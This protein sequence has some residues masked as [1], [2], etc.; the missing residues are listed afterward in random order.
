MKPALSIFRRLMPPGRPRADW[1]SATD[2]ELVLAARVQDAAGKGAFVEIVRRHQGAVAAVAF[3][4]A[5]R[6]AW[7]DDITQ[8]TF[9]RVWQRLGTLREPGKFKAWLMRIAH[10]CAV[11]AVRKSRL[12]VPMEEAALDLLATE[13]DAPDAAAIVREEEAVV[14]TALEQ[15]PEDLRLPLVLYYQKGQSSVEVAAALDLS[16]AA[17][18]QRLSR[19]RDALRDLV[20]ARVEGVLERVRPSP[21][22]LAGVA[23]AIGWLASPTVVAGSAFTAAAATSSA[24][25]VATTMST[26][27]TS[28]AIAA[29]LAAAA[30]PFGYG[31]RMGM[32][33]SPAVAEDPPPA[34]RT[35]PLKKPAFSDSALYAEWRKLHAEH[36]STASDMPALYKAITDIR[37]PVR[38]RVFRAAQIAEWAEIAP[39]AGLAFFLEKGRDGAQRD[40]FFNEWLRRDASAAVSAMLASPAGWEGMAWNALVEIAKRVPDRVAEITARLPEA[41]YQADGVIDAFAVMAASSGMDSARAAAESLTGP[42]RELALAGVAKAWAKTDVNAAI[43]WAKGLPDGVDRDEIIRR[44]LIGL[45]S[46]SPASA[47]DL[48]SSVPP[49]GKEGHFAST[50]GA[51]VLL[52]AVNTDYDATVAWLA[53]HPAQLGEDDLL[54][55]A[56]AVTERLNADPIAFLKRHLDDGSA[57]AIMP[58]IGNALLNKAGG[59]REAI[60]EWL[61]GQ[62]DSA[63]VAQLRREVISTA[64]YQDPESA[65]KLAGEMPN[66]PEGDQF[67]RTI[68]SNLL[69]NSNWLQDFDRLMAEAPERLRE[70]LV[71]SAFVQLRGDNLG[72]PQ[73]WLSRV[74]QGREEKRAEMTGRIASA[75][76]QQSPEEAVAWVS[77]LP[78]GGERFSAVTQVARTWISKEPYGASEWIAT[79]PAGADKDNAS[80]FLIHAIA[81]DSPGEAWQWVLAITDPVRRATAASY[82]LNV[83][84]RSDPDAA[85][86]WLE[87]A[88]FTP[89]EKEKVRTVLNGT[90]LPGGTP[91]NA[92]Q[93]VRPA[94]R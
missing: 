92:N 8:E 6:A 5:G 21:A 78:D 9:L 13:T 43:T 31:A 14:W 71:E 1:E 29:L 44:A 47:L 69:N 65:L 58:A 48:V 77:T 39:E 10:N 45:S 94:S 34:A 50:T 90:T 11:H 18:R 40:Q 51:R 32:E 27:K 42:N 61:K 35:E 12:C 53:A 26:S 63:A 36:G 57:S 87:S 89:R 4:V 86:Q 66:T 28:L 22:V 33:S 54:G 88:S 80:S 73:V 15:L 64:G 85:R 20:A 82:T 84:Q 30:L 75:W 79:L 7:I 41:D 38:R 74:N 81:A 19:A 70:P 2:S 25:T 55:M 3:V 59:Q 37:D 60:W 16:D 56:E 52:K 62:P 49:G 68:A 91:S 23:L 24:T 72:D 17:V 46:T 76:A 83:L 67:V 93:S